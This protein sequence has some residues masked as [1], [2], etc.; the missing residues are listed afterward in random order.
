MRAL[1]SI[2]LGL[3]AALGSAQVE[4]DAPIRFTGDEDQRSVEGIGAPIAD[5]VAVT[6]DVM[7]SGIVHWAGPSQAADTLVLSVQPPITEASVGLLIRF[8]PASNNTDRVWISCSDQGPYELLRHDGLPLP[9]GELLSGE[10]AEILFTG[11]N[12]IHL[13]GS[14]ATCPPGSIAVNA[15]TCM[16]VQPRTGL[17]FYDAADHCTER[18]GKLC[19]W[20]EYA[21]GCTVLGAQ[22][23]GMFSEWEW[24][25]DCSNHTHTADQAG[26]VNCQSQRTLSTITMT[27]ANARCCYHPR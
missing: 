4:I 9:P 27:P 11:A 17:L 2:S 8:L 25:D 20:D 12:W 5:S 1:F 22:L 16:D 21:V 24:I 3:L 18:G 23:T 19:T 7:S 26:R 10:V 15:R 6:V 13:N 14:H